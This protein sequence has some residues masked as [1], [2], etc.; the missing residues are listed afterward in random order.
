MKLSHFERK[1]FLGLLLGKQSRQAKKIYWLLV[2]DNCSLLFLQHGAKKEEEPIHI[3]NIALK[4]EKNSKDIEFQR[5]MVYEFT[6]S[7]VRIRPIDY[8]Y[9][10]IIYTLK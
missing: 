3:I 1:Y 10:T 9:L 4:I 6:Q 2:S 5:K 8:S 7:K